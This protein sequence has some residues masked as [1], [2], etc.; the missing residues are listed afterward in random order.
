MNTPAHWLSLLTAFVHLTTGM[1]QLLRIGPPFLPPSWVTIYS[2]VPGIDWLWL[3]LFTVTGVIALV[4][5]RR[6][7][8]LRFSCWL[9]ASLALTWGLVGLFN[10]ARGAPG[11]N[12]PG[13]L[14]NLQLAGAMFVLAYYVSKGVRGD[15][16]D[17]QIGRL[18]EQMDKEQGTGG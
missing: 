9:A 4:G 3:G 11:G 5:I 17:R 10:T 14:Q 16:I 18:S 13:S 1:S 8:A 7:D 15:R 12:I 6:P 2:I